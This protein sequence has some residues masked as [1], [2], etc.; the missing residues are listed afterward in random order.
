[1]NRWIRSLASLK[2]GVGIL[3]VLGIALAAG[4]IV[5]SAAGNETAARLVYDALWFRALLALFAMNVACSLA[6]RWPWDRKHWGYAATHGSM[7]VILAG[8]LVT[9]LFKVEG[10]LALWEGE[11]AAAFDPTDGLGNPLPGARVELPFSVRLVAFEMDTY[12]GTN[13]P[14]MFRSRVVVSDPGQRR[15]FP[16]AIEMN[17]ELS[18]RGWKLFQSGY[19]MGPERDRTILAVSRDPGQPLVFAGYALLLAGMVTV[20]ATRIAQRRALAKSVEASRRAPRRAAKV[21]A[22]ALALAAASAARAAWLPDVETSERLARLPVQHDGRVMPLDTMA[23]EAVWKVTGSRRWAAADPVAV[24]LGWS[25]DPAGWASEPLVRIE[26]ELAAAIGLPARR[27]RASY[28]ELAANPRLAAILA[29]AR[30]RDERHERRGGL[31]EMALAVE[32]RTR[33]LRGFLDRTSLRV[34]AV[35]GDPHAAWTVPGDLRQ[36]ADLLA[37]ARPDGAASSRA[38]S[39]ELAYN[40][41]RPTRLSWWILAAAT[42]VSLAAWRLARRWLDVL[43]VSALAAGFA[44]MTWGIAARWAIAGRIPAANMYESLLFLGWGVGL[45]AVLALVILRGRLLVLNAA[46]GAALTMALADLLPLDPF[47]HPVPPVLSGTIWLAIHV[48]IIMVSYSVLALGVVLAH[49]QVGCEI[50]AGG[51]RDLVTKMNDLL[52]WYLHVGAILL[53]AGIL[54]G[55]VWAASSWGRYW[56]WDPKEVWSLVAFL[57]YLAILH[58]RLDRLFGPFGMAALSIGAFWTIVMTY[59]GVNDILAAGLHSYGFGGAG[60]ARWLLVLAASETAFLAAGSLAYTANRKK[61]PI[62]SGPGG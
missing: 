6:D 50:F 18:H 35:P 24:V 1:M 32:A 38:I 46:A 3:L 60:V 43:A 40:R 61:Q 31:P 7:L 58:G 16:F 20:L 42:A 30:A 56:G 62:L 5:E 27:T 2:L 15:S 17:S 59:V 54:S 49:F 55:S 11:E 37:Y 4:T 44:V 39:R 26:P 9:D 8:A 57:A 28:L 33:W 53:V 48:P 22:L 10:T 25:F 45:F 34:V 52:Y 36:P 19:E 41:L 12:P 14:A 51:R 21:A 13:R 47:I 29:E 23:R